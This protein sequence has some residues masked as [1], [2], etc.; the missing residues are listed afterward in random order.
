MNILYVGPYL[1]NSL[2]GFC[3]RSTI[4]NLAKNIDLNIDVCSLGND[5]VFI[6]PAQNI[7]FINHNR[8]KY[9]YVIEHANIN[10]IS[11]NTNH[12][13]KILIPI[14]NDF[15]TDIT[16]ESEI[17]NQYQYIVVQ[18]SEDYSYISSIL[19]NKYIDKIKYIPIDIGTHTYPQ[20]DTD[21]G[22][23]KYQKNILSI[24]DG[25]NQNIGLVLSLIRAF[26]YH[27]ARDSSTSLLI[28]LVNSTE[29]LIQQLNN[30]SISCFKKLKMLYTINKVKLINITKS[31]PQVIGLMNSNICH[32][33]IDCN[34]NHSIRQHMLG[35]ASQRN[36]NIM[37]DSDLYMNNILENEQN[38]Y[39]S[40]QVNHQAFCKVL[41]KEN[42][43]NNSDTVTAN[44]TTE[45]SWNT[46]L[47]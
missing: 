25:H 16:I 11:V 35:V 37:C 31:D 18:S 3:S 33:Y 5:R 10:N 21:I 1:S 8:N 28:G 34:I 41:S 46:I 38:I 7:N 29:S 39:S 6:L 24:V 30:Y 40:Q 19:S 14:I 45:D 22:L 23:F 26:V 43:N 44:Q 47:V 36:L 42:T 4:Y 27:I 17:F 13:K 20:T 12:R 15:S 2:N 32:H 9:D